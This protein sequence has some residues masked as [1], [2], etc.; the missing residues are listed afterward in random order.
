MK[1]MCA[2]LHT[3]IILLTTFDALGTQAFQ[4]R[5]HFPLEL[6]RKQ[7][8]VQRI[9]S[10]SLRLKAEEERTAVTAVTAR[11]SREL[12]ATSSGASCHDQM[13]ADKPCDVPH[14]RAPAQSQ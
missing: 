14:K 5:R 10:G 6:P 4:E 13:R 8:Q 9:P 11:G 12:L 7:A 2:S 3:S 1:A